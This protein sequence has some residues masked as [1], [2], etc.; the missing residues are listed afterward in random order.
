[1][2]AFAKAIVRSLLIVWA[3]LA[4]NAAFAQIPAPNGNGNG[5]PPAKVEEKPADPL[6]RDTPAGMVSGFI[7]AAAEQNYDKAAQYLDLSQEK[8]AWGPSVAQQLQRILDQGGYVFSRLR[9]SADAAGDQDDGLAPDQDRFGAV[10]TE[11]GSVDLIAQRV[12]G[13]DGVKIWLVSAKTVG[14]LPALSRTVTSSLVD[15]ILPYA[16]RDEY[17]LAGVPAGH[18]LAVIVLAVLTFSIVWAITAAILWVVFRFRGPES[19][20]SRVLSASALP[21]RLFLTAMLLR[22]ALVMTGV[23]IV[24]RQHMSG[25]TELLGWIALSW[26]VWR[27]VDALAEFAIARM[28]LRGRL[29]M[30]SAVTFIRRSVKFALVAFAAIAGLNAL[31]YNVTAGLAALGIG[32]IAIALG[33]QKTIEHLVGSLT[34][35]TDQPMRVGDFCKFGETMGT[36]EDIGMRST[37]IR[38]LDRTLVTVPN[39]ALAAVQIENFSR[40]DKFWYHPILDLRYETTPDQMRSLIATMRE[41]LLEHPKV[42]NDPARVRL[43]GFGPSSLRVEIFAYIHAVSMDEFLEVQEELT[44]GLMEIVEAAGTGFAFPSQTVYVARDKTPSAGRSPQLAPGEQPESESGGPQR[45]TG[46][47]ARA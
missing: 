1:M 46:A 45:P 24:A 31:G 27:V 30:L 22:I 47:A 34:L 20:V 37:R 19:R 23:A 40:R 21:I 3:L 33:A 43:L 17:R 6:G 41:M 5:T 4:V 44:L 38:T 29:S 16:L 2:T 9:L 26:I 18:W 13:K 25:A 32:G 14:D 39:G 10:R 15:K 36:I 42:D 28:T 7:N 35:V 8:G 12:D 11:N